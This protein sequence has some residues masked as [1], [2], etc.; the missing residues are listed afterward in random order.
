[1][2]S[3]LGFI[4]AAIVLLSSCKK[5]ASE[6]N[7]HHGVTRID[8]EVNNTYVL[9][10]IEFEFNTAHDLTNN[11]SFRI[12]LI[13]NNNATSLSLMVMIEDVEGI[14][15][16]ANPMIISETEVIKD[17]ALHAYEFNILDHVSSASTTSSEVDLSKIRKLQIY[18]NSDINGKPAKGYFWLD[19][20]AFNI[21]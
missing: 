3:K 17:N 12:E 7:V 16:N 9:P 4:Y 5:E 1:M 18:I 14:R 11:T 2:K 15:N 21:P 19:K 8:Y 20:L 6:V 10:H 13:A